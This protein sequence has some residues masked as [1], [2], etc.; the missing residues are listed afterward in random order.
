MPT[1]VL[2]SVPAALYARLK[3]IAAIPRR[4]LTQE[5]LHLLETA[6]AA[7]EKNAAAPAASLTGR[8]YWS[9]RPL[10][11][12]FAAAH[13]AGAFA[14]GQDSTAGISSDRNER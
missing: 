13:A 2:K 12:S 11:P 4:S 10:L 8:A 5:A 14:G 9:T 1:L 6:L 3:R 7:E